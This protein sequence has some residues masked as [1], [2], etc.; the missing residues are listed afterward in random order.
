MG[1]D[2]AAYQSGTLFRK[3]FFSEVCLCL[4][5][6][7]TLDALSTCD[8]RQINLGMIVTSKSFSPC[9][10]F[11]TLGIET[12]VLSSKWNEKI[13]LWHSLHI[14]LFPI[15]CPLVFFSVC[16]E[17][18]GPLNTNGH[19]NLHLWNVLTQVAKDQGC[20]FL[21][22]FIATKAYCMKVLSLN[23]MLER[24]AHA[25]LWSSVRSCTRGGLFLRRKQSYSCKLLLPSFFSSFFCG[26]FLFI[27]WT[28]IK[29][30]S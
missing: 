2:Q 27:S 29:C 20:I 15:V 22:F 28:N 21:F 24:C 12:K 4:S 17:E 25:V 8:W 11:K 19:H 5:T 14:L 1:T 6:D 16:L 9:Y 3:H 7:C 30:Y 18:F 10:S 13:S 26:L 23:V